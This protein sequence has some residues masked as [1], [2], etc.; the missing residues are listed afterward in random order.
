MQL[1][2]ALQKAATDPLALLDAWWLNPHPRISAV[3]ATLPGGAP[4]AGDVDA[5]CVALRTTLR[6]Q[7]GPLFAVLFE[8]KLADVQRRLALLSGW[9]GDARLANQ[10]ERVLR[11]VPWS[12][13]GSRPVW[14]QIFALVTSSKDPRFVALA[15]ELP[16]KWALRSTQQRW[17]TKAFA[18]AV[19]SL[20]AVT[21]LTPEESSL[22][23]VI[24]RE[25]FAA[26]PAVK[27]SRTID[28]AAVYAA[29]RDDAPRLVLADALLEQ[30]EAR[31]E[32]LS[33]QLRATKTPAE[34]KRERALL[35]A[36]AKKWLEPFGSSLGAE[37]TWRRGFPVEG[38]VKF[39]NAADAGKYG[40]LTEW[41]TFEVL[42]WSP[43]RSPDHQRAAG[44]IGPAFRHLRAAQ[45][46]YVPHLL[47]SGAGTW[48]L[49]KVRGLV[50]SAEGLRA[51]VESPTLPKLEALHVTDWTFTAQWLEGVRWGGVQEFGVATRYPSQLP[52]V[53]TAVDA[54]SLKRLQ[55]G[56]ALRFHR[57]DDGSLSRL[58][59]LD[60]RGAYR[61]DEQ[62]AS[63]PEG[64]VSSLVTPADRHW[65]TG[66]LGREL[67]RVVKKQPRR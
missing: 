55:W 17:M 43:P 29:P 16:P 20:P 27:R 64:A 65:S 21:E 26:R 41:A 13:T 15:K 60:W 5:W 6:A 3:I 22:L 39:R 40:G 44:F 66:P 28:F 11:E 18:E 58:E 12:S 36:H 2:Q 52:D 59:L 42:T 48:A 63:L 31:G 54:S 61:V 51:V 25:A 46:M 32:L 57:A 56:G 67:E 30:G 24:E 34:E 14:T 4:F 33:L 45:D 47:A 19:R 8:G 37:V 53:L 38:L 10:L 1:H 7:L 23:Q 62:L 9:N 49:E 50:D 35:K